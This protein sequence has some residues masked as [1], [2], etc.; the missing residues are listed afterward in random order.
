MRI[1]YRRRQR[2]HDRNMHKM[3]QLVLLALASSV[4]LWP[5]THATYLRPTTVIS[6]DKDWLLEPDP[7][8][9]S[10]VVVRA[11]DNATLALE[12]GFLARVFAI[13]PFFA[14]WDVATIRGS[15]LRAISAEATVTLDG[16]TYAVGGGVPLLDDGSGN[17]CPLPSGIGPPNNC[18]TAYFNRSTPYAANASAFQYQSHWTSAPTAPFAWKPARH[19]PDMPW[20]PLGLRLSVN[21]T[22]PT[23]ADP[24][25]KDVVVTMHYEMYQG[26]PAMSKWMTVA[27]AQGGGTPAAAAG[28]PSRVQSQAEAVQAVPP[29][30]Q[31]PVCIQPCDAMLPPSS[32]E[33][34]WIVAPDSTGPVQLAGA[35]GLCLSLSAGT[36]YHSYNDEIDALPCNASDPMQLWR[37]RPLPA[38]AR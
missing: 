31:G 6:P 21:L 1:L 5:G 10:P 34:R 16:R 26:I 11:L 23:D 33:S 17:A 4:A 38:Q 15:A 14:T 9:A 13:S 7:R 22:A 35:Q 18:P 29:E 32:W 12:N 8:R 27:L 30:Q 19:A 25:H 3:N 28:Q 24:A 20:P 2:A 37:F 36:S